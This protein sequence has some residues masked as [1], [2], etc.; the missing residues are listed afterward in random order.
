MLLSPRRGRKAVLVVL[1][2]TLLLVASVHAKKKTPK[3][4]DI[5]TATKHKYKRC[6]K[7]ADCKDSGAPICLP[8][9]SDPTPLYAGRGNPIVRGVCV[10]CTQNCHCDV[11]EVCMPDIT[12]GD[13]MDGFKISTL[14]TR[15]QAQDFEADLSAVRGLQ[16]P[17]WCT[18]INKAQTFKKSKGKTCNPLL[19]TFSFFNVGSPLQLGKVAKAHTVNYY[20][21]QSKTG[22]RT[23]VGVNIL[24][25]NTN[26]SSMATNNTSCN[27]VANR[28]PA[29]KKCTGNECA[30]S[31]PTSNDANLFNG[32]FLNPSPSDSM[33]E[34]WSSNE[35]TPGQ[36]SALALMS[37][38]LPT[39]GN[40]LIYSSEA[41][42]QCSYGLYSAAAK[43][44]YFQSTPPL[45]SQQLKLN[46][47]TWVVFTN[48][49]VYEGYCS[50]GKCN[51]CADGT[52]RCMIN[53]LSYDTT[54]SQAAT[55]A[56]GAT[57]TGSNGQVCIRGEWK[58]FWYND[59]TYRTIPANATAGATAVT[60]VFV[61]FV[62]VL[63]LAF[64]MKQCISALLKL[65]A[66]H[67]RNDSLNPK[68]TGPPAYATGE[69]QQDEFSEQAAQDTPTDTP[70]PNPSK[71]S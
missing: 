64:A 67:A 36:C 11:G 47:Q 63:V 50:Q 9:F 41:G 22:T 53:S 59:Q 31:Y 13:V 44:L 27:V 25:Y 40:P 2:I 17:S 8:V 4:K 21:G 57:N 24:A 56:P 48:D 18:P 7:N 14:A 55:S 43:P 62:F 30:S 61:S 70:L 23:N 19:D 20:T 34:E 28:Q 3:L 71:F 58:E 5:K 1:V 49:Y 6:A 51:Q 35:G 52:S 26:P 60:A 42:G 29:F 15:Q 54:A 46:F 65:R 37:T 32:N 45:G 33:V 10:P 39:S 16:M 66:R 68:P 12:V 69:Q 38:T